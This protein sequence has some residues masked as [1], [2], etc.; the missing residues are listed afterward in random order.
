[1]YDICNSVAEII[2]KNTWFSKNSDLLGAWASL[3]C[4]VHCLAL[5]AVIAVSFL[6]VEL[7]EEHWHSLDYIF[8]V[9]SF[10]AVLYASR[11]SS[12]LWIK[13][14]LWLTFGIFTLGLLGHE[15]YPWMLWISVSASFALMILHLVNHKSCSRVA[16]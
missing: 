6:S 10:V 14:G 5:P 15:V 8:I 11:R 9:I 2:M 4:V 13:V 1:M 3:I 16:Y 7:S 12:I